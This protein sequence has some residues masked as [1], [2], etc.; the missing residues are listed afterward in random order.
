[1]SPTTEMDSMRPALVFDVNE[2]LLDLG[3]LDPGFSEALGGG[4]LREWF[5][6]LLNSSLVENHLGRH[7]PFSELALGALLTVG[8]E[9][10]VALTDAEVVALLG[11]LRSLQ[12]HPDVVDGLTR[13]KAAGFVMAALTNTTAEALTPLLDQA[14]IGQ[15]LDHHLSVDGVGRFKPAPEVYLY[16]ALQLEV[17]IGDMMMVAAHDWD[18]IGARSV[19][20]QGAYVARPGAVWGLPDEPPALVVRTIADLADALV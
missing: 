18:I 14:G 20:A 8:K 1:M 11:P 17:E 5:L 7:R 4:S 15:L 16:G 10:E 13:L 2:T 9:R 3:S 12:P 19:G 6:T